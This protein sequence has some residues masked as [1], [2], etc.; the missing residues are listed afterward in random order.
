MILLYRYF[1]G[2]IYLGFFFIEKVYYGYMYFSSL[3][4]EWV[5]IDWLL[6]CVCLGN[7][8]RLISYLFDWW[9]WVGVV[10]VVGGEL[11]KGVW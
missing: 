8:C 2:S 1:K 10:C 3:W 11:F 6:M 9:V 4:C 7:L 5:L